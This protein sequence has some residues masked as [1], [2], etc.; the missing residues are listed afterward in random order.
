MSTTTAD[1]HVAAGTRRALAS[2]AW[3][4]EPRRQAPPRARRARRRRPPPRARERR[5]DLRRRVG[6]RRGDRAIGAERRRR[7]PTIQRFYTDNGPAALLQ[8]TLVHGIAGVALAVFAVTLARRLTL[9]TGRPATLVAAAGLAAAAVSLLQ[10]AMEIAL[11]RA[12]DGGHVGANATLFHAVNLADTVKLVLLAVAIAA[13]TRMAAAALAFPR[14]LR[15]LGYALAAILVVGGAA[16]VVTSD[17]LSAVL[18]LSL[19]LLLLWVGAVA[20]VLTRGGD[21][22]PVRVA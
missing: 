14:W 19:V 8:A 18:A 12:S 9:L 15:G 6:D 1:A 11:N 17:A 4:R 22:Q 13:A 21:T 5:R 16:F 20:A 2:A 10:Y 7:R 3:E